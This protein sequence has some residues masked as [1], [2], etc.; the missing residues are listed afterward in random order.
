MLQLIE[1]MLE[2]WHISSEDKL[3]PAAPPHEAGLLHLISLIVQ[4][5]RNLRP[6]WYFNSTLGRPARLYRLV[7]HEGASS[8][9]CC[10][11][12]LQAYESP[13]HGN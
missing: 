2:L 10:L 4:H 3:D 8:L 12:D 7:L 11:A 9:E 5:Q 1:L 13:A 6:Y